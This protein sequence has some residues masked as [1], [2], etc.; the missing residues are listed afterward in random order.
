MEQCFTL[1]TTTEG[2]VFLELDYQRAISS[3]LCRSRLCEATRHASI[4]KPTECRLSL[5]LQNCDQYESQLAEKVTALRRQFHPSRY[6]QLATS[7]RT[8]KIGR[9]SCRERE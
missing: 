7:E 3:P 2:E 1:A 6:V 8:L 9:A 5:I 4:F